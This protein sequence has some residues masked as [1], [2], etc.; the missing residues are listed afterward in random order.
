MR[1]C[2]HQ[3]GT[4]PNGITWHIVRFIRVDKY[5]LLRH[6]FVV[7]QNAL[8]DV[9]RVCLLLQSLDGVAQGRPPSFRRYSAA[10]P[11][12]GVSQFP[13]LLARQTTLVVVGQFA[14]DNGNGLVVSGVFPRKLLSYVQQ[15]G[16]K[17]SVGTGGLGA[18]GQRHHHYSN[19]YK[20]SHGCSS[21]VLFVFKASEGILA[22]DS[23][24]TIMRCTNFCSRASARSTSSALVV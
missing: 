23:S 10:H 12:D 14:Y 13:E 4:K 7:V 22:L 20:S 16:P 8:L 18:D 9:E 19:E 3:V 6:A 24:P 1:Y 17:V 5:L 11:F 15:F 2:I 21:I